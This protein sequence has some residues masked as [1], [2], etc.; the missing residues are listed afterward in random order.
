VK[1]GTPA[2]LTTVA[3]KDPRVGPVN[4]AAGPFRPM[5]LS[6]VIAGLGAVENAVSTRRWPC[7]FPFR[8]RPTR[9]RCQWGR[10]LRAADPKTR[11]ARVAAT[12]LAR[13]T[14]PP[15][16]L[17]AATGGGGA[18]ALATPGSTQPTRPDRRRQFR[19]A[20]R[21]G[22]G[23]GEDAGEFGADQY[24]VP[25]P[26]PAPRRRGPDCSARR[27][28]D[29]RGSPGRSR[30]CLA[31]FVLSPACWSAGARAASTGNWPT[32]LSPDS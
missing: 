32:Y 29:H 31:I 11:P 17:P 30:V 9:D 15:P 28:R 16:A 10:S 23:L 4:A 14:T 8:I 18:G 5:L 21:P 27:H 24:Q 13:T 26:L 12:A 25:L 1:D 7:R 22:I 19:T 2:P 6:R 20:D 3:A